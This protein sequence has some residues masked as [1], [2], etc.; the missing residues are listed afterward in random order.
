MVKNTDLTS[1]K[2]YNLLP[3]IIKKFYLASS[4]FIWAKKLKQLKVE[5]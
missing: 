3:S 1:Y 2:I 4:T 5:K